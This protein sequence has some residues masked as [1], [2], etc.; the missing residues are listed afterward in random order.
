MNAVKALA[1][2]VVLAAA[3]SASAAAQT[4]QRQCNWVGSNYICHSMSDNQYSTTYT[5]CGANSRSGSSGCNS[6][7]ERKTPPVPPPH[8]TERYVAP[9]VQAG[10]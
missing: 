10:K 4:Y 5:T 1:A 3:C 9:K 7:T 6:Y 2:A 8:I